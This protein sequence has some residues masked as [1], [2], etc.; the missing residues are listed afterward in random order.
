MDKM[1]ILCN[2]E[3]PSEKLFYKYRAKTDYFIAADGGGNIARQFSDTP[4]VVIGDLDSFEDRDTDN[5]RII[6][7][8][9]Q[10]SNDLEKALSLAQQ[11]GGSHIYIL[12]ATGLRLDHTLKNLSV[13]K[14]FNRQFEDLFLID[15]FGKSQILPHS[16]SKELPIGTLVSLFPLSGKVTNITT[17]GLKYSLKDETLENGV[18]D[19]SSN[20][21]VGTPITITHKKGDL[22]FFEA[23]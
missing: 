8:P 14:Q 19:G 1:L 20:T 16:F 15:N 9:G 13:L 5:F 7:R 17:E 12:G 23:F 4:D 21:V 18:R 2:G 10:E 3:P 22:L 6:H 11:K